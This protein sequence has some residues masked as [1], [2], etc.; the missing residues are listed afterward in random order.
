MLPM[1]FARFPERNATKIE[2]LALEYNA[3]SFRVDGEQDQQLNNGF[4]RN[5]QLCVTHFASLNVP[6]NGSTSI[7]GP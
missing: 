2:K 3:Y 7:D 4:V 6:A 5:P 1:H